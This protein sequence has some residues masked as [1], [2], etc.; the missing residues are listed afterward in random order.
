MKMYN[1]YIDNIKLFVVAESRKK[2]MECFIKHLDR[3]I[4]NE[5][6]SQYTDLKEYLLNNEA[7]IKEFDVGEVLEERHND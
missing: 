7:T 6:F 4:S 2:A 5:C 1:C 3:S